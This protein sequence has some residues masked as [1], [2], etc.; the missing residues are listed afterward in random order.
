MKSSN[1]SFAKALRELRKERR[2]SQEALAFDA[3][4]DR[5][6][7]SLLELGRRSPTLET[8]LALCAALQISFGEFAEKIE[9]ALAS[10]SDG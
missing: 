10:D 5:T 7:I 6:Y 8:M 4:L 3:G 9:S 1:A 2:I